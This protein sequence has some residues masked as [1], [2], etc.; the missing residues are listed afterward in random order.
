MNWLLFFFFATQIIISNGLQG[1]KGKEAQIALRTNSKN[2]NNNVVGLDCE[3]VEGTVNGRKNVLMLGRVTVVNGKGEPIYD[4]YVRIGAKGKVTNYKT[5]VSGIRKE[6]LLVGKGDV[7]V[8]S[9][10]EAQVNV[11]KL[12]KGK[13][14]AGHQLDCDFK[15]SV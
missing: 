14:L 6:N 5:E 1:Q 13:I 15:V 11:K 8:V 4:T 9:F 3:F 7:G 10:T 2:H 12:I